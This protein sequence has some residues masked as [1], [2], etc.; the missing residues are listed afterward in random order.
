MPFY[1]KAEVKPELIPLDKVAAS[2]RVITVMEAGKS[3]D[4]ALADILAG[5]ND[6]KAAYEVWAEVESEQQKLKAIDPTLCKDELEFKAK[7]AAEA[8]VANVNTWVLKA[9]EAAGIKA[10]WPKPE[11]IVEPKEVIGK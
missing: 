5:S 7:V 2:A 8:K 9:K 11:A 4:L 1:P 6:I 10:T 3:R